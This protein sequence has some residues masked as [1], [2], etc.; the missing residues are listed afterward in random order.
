MLFIM[1]LFFSGFAR[2]S[3][4]PVIAMT[5]PDNQSTFTAGSDIPLTADASEAE[6]TIAAVAFYNGSA[7]LGQSSKSP[8]TYTWADVPV[9][10]YTL[11]AVATDINEVSTTSTAVKVTVTPAPPTVVITSPANESSFSA[12]SDI[13]LA[14]TA[15]ETKGTISAIS[16]YNGSTLLATSDMASS[17]YNYTWANVPAGTYT[18]TAVATDA[19][20]VSGTSSP[21]TVTIT[22]SSAPL[23]AIT[24]P[25]SDSTFTAG[26][27]IAITA[28]SST[29]HE[30]I[31][32]V[33]FYD[34]TYYLGSTTQAPYTY[35]W[36]NVPAGTHSLT[37]EA[38][39]NNGGTFI[40]T[41]V[42]I[43]INPPANPVTI[44]PAGAQKADTTN[45]PDKS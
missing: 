14:A 13:N 26:S 25:A 41:P 31:R 8:Y 16:F 20:K 44:P 32:E 37:A 35:T 23:I 6:G 22:S 3:A 36:T 4:A 43:T 1:V 28:A 17:F 38:T 21:I 10:T 45:S 18:L 19:N 9:G 15:L 5:N 7:L 34:G 11:T 42:N 29:S 12:G 27:D 2:A 24:S 33:F 40:S 39:D 30:T